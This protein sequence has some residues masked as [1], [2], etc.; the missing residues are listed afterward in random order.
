MTGFKIA[1]LENL[2]EV[3]GE[4]GVKHM[5]ADYSCPQN[6]DIDDFLKNKAIQFSKMSWAK[7][8]LVFASFKDQVVLVG[9]FAL[10]LKTFLIRKDNTLNSKWRRRIKQ[11]ARTIEETGCYEVSAPLIAQLG[12]NYTNGYDKLISGDEL[13]K[14][15]CDKVRKIHA[16]MG[17]KIVYVE[18]EEIPKLIDF[19][20]SNGF[21]EFD[22]RNADRAERHT[23]KSE[24]LIQMIKFIE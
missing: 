20:C 4:A 22:K 17:G 23:V 13:L 11:F 6:P 5:L 14:M 1:N 10:A 8:H 15:A 12:K 21:F 16:L 24:R 18:C 2:L 9:Y 7:T 3:V 19:Y